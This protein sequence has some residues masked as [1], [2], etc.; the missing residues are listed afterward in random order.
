MIKP[1]RVSGSEAVKAWGYD[2]GFPSQYFNFPGPGQGFQ[3]EKL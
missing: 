3:L 2:I 1:A